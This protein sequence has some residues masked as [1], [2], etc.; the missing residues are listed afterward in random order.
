[1]KELADLINDPLHALRVFPMADDIT[2]WK[3]ILRGPKGT[4]YHR[5]YFSVFI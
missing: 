2:N 3:A 4:P 5:G 1:M